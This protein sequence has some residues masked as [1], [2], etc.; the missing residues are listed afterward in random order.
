MTLAPSFVFQWPHLER[1]F[2]QLTVRDEA[3]M[4]KCEVNGWLAPVSGLL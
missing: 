1:C 3:V 4:S 2:S